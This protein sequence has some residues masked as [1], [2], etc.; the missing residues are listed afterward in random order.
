MGHQTWQRW[1]LLAVIALLAISLIAGTFIS[2]AQWLQKPFP[3]F[4]LHENLTVGPYFLPHWTGMGGGLKTLDRVMSVEGRQLQHPHDLYELTRREPPGSKFR[5]QIRRGGEIIGLTLPSMIFTFHDWFLTFGIYLFTG[6]AF[7]AIGVTPYYLRSSSVASLPLCFMVTAVFVWFATT[8]DF[9]ASSVFPKEM[10]I[11]AFTLTPSA[12]IHL[13]LLLRHGRPIR[14]YRP[15]WLLMIYGISLMLGCWYSLTFS[16]PVENWTAVFRITYAYSCVGAVTFLLLLWSAVRETLSDLERTRLRVVLIGAL[17]GFLIPTLSTV[18]TS[19]FHLAIP[20]N[21]ALIPTVF[22]PLSVAYALLKYSLF[23]LGNTLKVGLSR[24]TLT[25]FLL[26]IYALVVFTLSA[27]VGIPQTGIVVPLLFSVL[28]VIVFKPLLGW[29]ERIVDRY[30]YRQEYDP[31][32]LQQEVSL[33]LRSLRPSQELGNGFLNVVSEQ[34]HID[35]ATLFYRTLGG[36]H[37]VVAGREGNVSQA[38][39]LLKTIASFWNEQ[40]EARYPGFS[41]EEVQSNPAFN[42]N[43]DELLE[44]FDQLKAELVIPVVFERTVRGVAAFG[45]KRSGREYSRDDLRLLGTL[46]DQLALSLENGR[47]FEESVQAQEKYR[48][49]YDEAQRANNRL[50][51]SDRIKKQFVANICHELRT[52]VSTIIGYGEVLLDP[53]FTGDNRAIL[54]RLVNNGQELSQMMDNLLDFSRMEADKLFTHFEPVN[55]KEVLA[56]LELMTQRLIRERPIAFRTRLESPIDTIESDAKKLQQ[57]LLQLLTNAL[58][59]TQRGEIEVRY[60]TISDGTDEFVEISVSDTGI[61]IDQR[62]QETIFEE[63]RQLDGSST[64]HYGGTGLGLSLCKKLAQ[65]LGGKISV[66]S[67]LGAGSVFSL[68]LPVRLPQSALSAAA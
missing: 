57:I 1:G 24:L 52:P 60:R 40:T 31:A 14:Q 20:Y 17:L 50:I 11:F 47:L 44:L 45:A 51:E 38:D 28:V 65:S 48:A 18:L 23:D 8:F 6:I 10:R 39:H 55:V 49:L 9:M 62:D 33:F 66:S 16:G 22:F 3:G 29:I 7:L 25:A 54:E 58:K 21:L 19:S 63:F 46:T 37:T 61:G 4:F 67:K 5:Y 13:G 12:G 30:V 27:S 35:A 26:M 43:K 2:S 68:L 15:L 32:T 59:F 41:R 36:R 42:Q 34:M 64:R 53:S 56:A